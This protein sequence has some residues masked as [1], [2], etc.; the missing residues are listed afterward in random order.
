M[1][2][3]TVCCVVVPHRDDADAEA[4]SMSSNAINGMR[5][6]K[7]RWDTLATLTAL[8]PG[9]V[10]PGIRFGMELGG[11]PGAFSAARLATRAT[12]NQSNLEGVGDSS[13]SIQ[14]GPVARAKLS[15]G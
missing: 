11:A 4:R 3:T 6:I 5:M 13:R 8:A 12:L 9:L 2:D 1:L 14:T 10:R 7:R 15:H